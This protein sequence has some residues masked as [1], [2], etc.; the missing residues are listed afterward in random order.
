M[1]YQSLGDQKIQSIRESIIFIIRYR[2]NDF[3]G[4]SG[5]NSSRAIA[6]LVWKTLSYIV[7]FF[8]YLIINILLGVYLA[9]FFDGSLLAGFG[10]VLMGYTII[11]LLLL[12]FREQIEDA[13]RQKLAAQ[14]IEMK[15]KLNKSLDAMPQM[16][17]SVPYNF[18]EQN[19]SMKP[20]E[21]LLKSNK[22]NR[23]R[24]EAKQRELHE[25]LVDVKKNYKQIAFTMATARVE[26]SMPLGSHI[27][28][29]MHFLEPAPY[30]EKKQKT[31][32]W[33]K[34]LPDKFRKESKHRGDAVRKLRP[35]LPYVA[36]AWKIAKP[37]LT[38]FA[39]NKGQQLLLKKLLKKKK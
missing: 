31:S 10:C 38:A 6:S 17:L 26:Q 35:Y 27:A 7:I 20:Y 28:T 11:L 15:S 29:V 5:A 23:Q 14:V 9:R 21:A 2:L 1:T 25:H 37:A 19:Q 3:L 8:L 22:Q 4:T 34:I 18:N 13:I 32:L 33:S 36:F 39:M 12:L 24:A 30:R 16:R